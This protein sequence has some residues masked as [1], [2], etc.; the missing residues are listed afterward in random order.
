ML[1]ELQGL[2]YLLVALTAN[3]VLLVCPARL[4]NAKVDHRGLNVLLL[5]FDL[6]LDF[7]GELARTTAGLRAFRRMWL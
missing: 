3:A 4:F 6:L 5:L 2:V 1:A 7:M